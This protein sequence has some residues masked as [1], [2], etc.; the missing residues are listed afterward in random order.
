MAVVAEADD[1]TV[2]G[3]NANHAWSLVPGG[4][5]ML[6]RYNPPFT[7]WFLKTNEVMVEVEQKKAAA[8]P[9]GAGEM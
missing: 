3:G 4:G 7:L 2:S 1:A 5:A 8:A 6:A 9:A